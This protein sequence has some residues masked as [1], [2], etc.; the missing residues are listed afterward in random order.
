MKF[1]LLVFPKHI[2]FN[3]FSSPT[4]PQPTKA[5]NGGGV[6]GNTLGNQP[7]VSRIEWFSSVDSN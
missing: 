5:E 4:P 6:V 7:P 2:S 1:T 3:I